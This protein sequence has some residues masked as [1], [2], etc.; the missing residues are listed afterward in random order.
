MAKQ[1]GIIKLKGTIG[2]ISF[3]KTADGHLALAMGSLI[4]LA[5]VLD[6]KDLEN[7]S[8]IRFLTI[9]RLPLIL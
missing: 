7:V 4:K 2:G 1:T 8:Y 3:Y 5:K 9:C 6:F